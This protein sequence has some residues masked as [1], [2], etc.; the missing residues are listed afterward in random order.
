MAVSFGS[1]SAPGAAKLMEMVFEATVL[2]GAKAVVCLN[3]SNLGALRVPDDIY[4]TDHIPHEWLL[5]QVQGF[6]HHG[7][8]GHTAIGLRYGIPM[9]V[10]PFFLDQ[11]FWAAEIYKQETGPAALDHR[12]LTSQQLASKLRD[13]LSGKYRHRCSGMANRIQSEQDGAEVAAATVARLQ[14]AAAEARP[15]CDILPDL[16]AT[17]K[18]VDTGI[19]LSGGAAACLISQK[20]LNW[21]D[22]ELVSGINWAERRLRASG[23]FVLVI[24]KITNVICSVFSMAFVMLRNFVDPWAKTTVKNGNSLGKGDPI[25]QARIKQ[26]GYDLQIIGQR[27][28]E[29]EPPY[30]A[31]I[32]KEIVAN[33]RVLSKQRLLAKLANTS[34]D[35]SK[36]E[37]I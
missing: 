31:S 26:A 27:A 25:R 36:D 18:N 33:W 35:E 10:L 37:D 9:L 32:E 24:G 20:L 15:S 8:A 7:G 19:H 1:A 16:K 14:V 29:A 30:A 13:L 22:L 17:W 23:K 11:Y 6:I 12:T 5:P 2:V 28:G 4:V 3:G 21:S 34:K